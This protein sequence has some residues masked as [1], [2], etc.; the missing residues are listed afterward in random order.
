MPVARATPM[1]PRAM[2]KNT[3]IRLHQQEE[4]PVLPARTVFGKRTVSMSPVT[5]KVPA[6]VAKPTHAAH[7]LTPDFTCEHRS[8]PVPP[9]AHRLMEETDPRSN[10]RTSTLRRLSRKRTYISTISRITFGEE[11]KYRNGLAGLR[12][13]GM[14]PPYPALLTS[15]Y[16]W[17]DRAFLTAGLS[18]RRRSD[19]E[20]TSPP[21]AVMP[22]TKA[23]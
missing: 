19:V 14:R 9:K 23:S 10:S 2:A 8:E 3:L 15:G 16:T 11:L 18:S 12:G 20:R 4:R 13:R 22:A 17:L 21:M 6:P 1:T 5:A 7:P